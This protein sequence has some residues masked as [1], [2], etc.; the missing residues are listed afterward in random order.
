LPVI[1]GIFQHGSAAQTP[2]KFRQKKEWKMKREINNFFTAVLIRL[3]N[4]KRLGRNN[5]EKST[6]DAFVQK[7][8]KSFKPFFS[9]S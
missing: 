6:M 3:S 1:V 2:R 4:V 9:K 8:F 5:R 7:I